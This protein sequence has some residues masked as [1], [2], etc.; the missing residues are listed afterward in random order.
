VPPADEGLDSFDPSGGELDHRLVVQ[1]ELAVVDGALEIGLELQALQGGVVHRGFEHLV[2]ALPRFLGHVHRNVGVPQELLGALGS[3]RSR[4]GGRDADGGADEDLLALEV[5]RALERRED[6]R[7]NLGGVDAVAAVLEQDR[8]LVPSEAS[9]G[10]RLPER[11]LQALADLAQH[12]VTGGMTERVVDRLEV[13]QVHEQDGDREVVARLPLDHV[14]D[15]VLEQRPVRQAGDRVV[16]G[17]VLELLLERLAFGHVT[18]VEDDPFHVLVV[19]QV[20]PKGLD[21]QP[22]VVAVLHAELGEPRVGVALTPAGREELQH[23]RSILRLD[24]DGQLRPLQLAGRV[25]EHAFDRRADVSDLRVGLD[26]H[27]HVRGVLDQR[28]ESRLALPDEQDLGRERAIER[29]GDL[30]GQS[31]QGVPDR[32]R[33]ARRSGHHEQTLELL[34][35]EQRSVQHERGVRRH[36]E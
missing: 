26:D 20:G 33:D 21:V 22:E 32:T 14:L 12:P 8:E 19:Q 2:A 11:V 13:V 7:C 36:T 23:A 5:E 4:V 9:G 31:L 25:A 30:R 16:E 34:L 24:Q 10:V 27:D 6:P 28:G 35:H 15:A 1:D 18:G 3:A 17:L 29:Q